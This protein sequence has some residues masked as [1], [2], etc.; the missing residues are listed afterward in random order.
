MA[1]SRSIEASKRIIKRGPP[2]W[3]LSSLQFSTD[4][5][6]MVHA[7]QVWESWMGEENR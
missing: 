6:Y 5:R 2:T 3:S 1:G 7:W 4:R